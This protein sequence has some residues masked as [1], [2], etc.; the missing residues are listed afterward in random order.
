M[1]KTLE[2]TLPSLGDDGD[3]VSSAFVSMWL[4]GIGATLRAGDDLLEV[5]TD[6][7]AFVVPCPADGVLRDA[8]AAGGRGPA[9]RRA[10]H[11]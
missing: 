8:G 10:G 11:T 1:P 3:A 5:N 7:A 2:V 6:K 4:V 9:G